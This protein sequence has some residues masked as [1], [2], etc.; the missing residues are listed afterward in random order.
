MLLR[1]AGGVFQ[2]ADGVLLPDLWF[3]ASRFA[4]W[5]SDPLNGGISDVMR[6]EFSADELRNS[7]G[8]LVVGPVRWFS[9][10]LLVFR[11]LNPPRDGSSGVG[12][13]GSR[14]A[15]CSFRSIY[16]L[17]TESEAFLLRERA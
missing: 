13:G 6:L 12:P 14:F 15:V 10:V 5:T 11:K 4:F 1:I 3:D 7:D 2:G 17:S 8:S 16:S 9:A